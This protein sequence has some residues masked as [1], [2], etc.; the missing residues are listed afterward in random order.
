M[1]HTS[2]K[3]KTGAYSRPAYQSQR[4]KTGHIGFRARSIAAAAHLGLG[5]RQGRPQCAGDEPQRLRPN[6]RARPGKKD[7]LKRQ[8]RHLQIGQESPP[9]MPGILSGAWHVELVFMA[10]CAPVGANAPTG[11]DIRP[12][13]RTTDVPA[14]MRQVRQCFSSSVV[15][16]SPTHGSF[17]SLYRSPTKAANC[18]GAPGGDSASSS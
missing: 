17:I 2:Q 18:G 8:F 12:I 9:N 4:C 16:R 13:H 1:N 14:D 15:A 7:R 3:K 11:C 6:T 5:H 10:R